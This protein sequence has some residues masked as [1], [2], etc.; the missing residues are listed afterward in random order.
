MR[1]VTGPATIGLMPAS[2]LTEFLTPEL[3]DQLGDAVTVIDTGSR[4]AYVSPRAAGLI[5]RRAVDLV[6]LPIE[7]VFPGVADTEQYAACLRALS[8]QVRQ[9][10]VWYDEPASAWFEQIALPMSTGLVVIVNNISDQQLAAHRS[11]QLVRLGES[12]AQATTDLAINE[13]LVAGVLP[14]MGAA[15]GSI[16][17]IDEE[18]AVA[19]AVAW[20]SLAGELAANWQEYPLRTATPGIRAWRTGRPVYAESVDQDLT[21][22]PEVAAAVARTGWRAL[23]ALPLVA[24]RMRLGALVITFATERKFDVGDQQFLATTAAM[25]AQALLRARLLALQKSSLGELQRQ[26]LPKRLPVVAGLALAARYVASDATAEIGGDWYDVVPLPGGSAGIVMG[27]VEGHDLAAAA[28]MGLVRSAVRAYAGE[29]HPPAVVLERT[30]LFLVGLGRDRMVTLA[31]CQLHPRDHLITTVSAGH[32]AL[33][34]VATDG[35]VLEVPTDTGPP[36]GVLDSGMHW[37]ETTSTLPAGCALALFTDGLIEVRGEDIGRG[38]GR[39]RD[40][41]HAHRGATPDVIADMLLATRVS[42][43][44]DDVALLIARLDVTDEVPARL[45]RHRLPATPASVLHARRFTRQ[46]LSAWE[47]D[48]DCATS[49]ELVVSELITNAARHGEDHIEIA[50]SYTGHLLRIEV[51]DDS[52]RMP[53]TSKG[54]EDGQESTSGRGLR[55]VEA[56]ATRWGVQSQDLSKVVWAEF[57]L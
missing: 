9:R 45:A 14:L 33:Q 22:T 50:L 29:G 6:G 17:L 30:N 56:F 19:R 48:H 40:T 25:A 2:E 18:R 21:T 5:G 44:H 34:A 1:K 7:E 11:E 4:Y 46:L 53:K 20:H 39:V 43:G 51:T 15:D 37:L 49:V 12:L 54:S 52:H 13:A 28:L 10:L 27:D 38:F 8:T 47:V 26:L 57:D 41:L 42:T 32:P 36:L 24:G 23:A 31:Y 3:L 55:L 35:V 16:L